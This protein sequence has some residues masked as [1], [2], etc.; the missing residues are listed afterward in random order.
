MYH[1]L[2]DYVKFDEL[3][4]H[5]QHFFLATKQQE[6]CIILKPNNIQHHPLTNNF[7]SMHL[8]QENNPR[9]ANAE[10][11]KQPKYQNAKLF[12]IW[13]I[14]H[15]PA[16]HKHE[17]IT[18]SNLIH[19]SLKKPPGII[20]CSD[21]KRKFEISK[22]PADRSFESNG[23]ADLVKWDR[24]LANKFIWR[25]KCIWN[26]TVIVCGRNSMAAIPKCSFPS[27]CIDFI[28]FASLFGGLMAH[29]GVYLL[30]TGLWRLIAL[31][32]AA[33]TNK[34]A[35]C[36]R[37]SLLRCRRL[38]RDENLVIMSHYKKW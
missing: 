23:R 6:R 10:T 33:F 15:V 4:V 36:S 38:I 18:G 5:N 21:I 12:E 27:E 20:R 1:K 28:N 14:M 26:G 11:S 16:I 35:N 37:G 30:S 34:H 31:S 3:V 29:A 22:T 32:S 8:Q 25:E 24:N 17:T 19:I 9:Y 2:L 13:Y 7:V